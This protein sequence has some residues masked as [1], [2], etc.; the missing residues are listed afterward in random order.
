MTDYPFY[1][2]F[3]RF[4]HAYIGR[5]E[6]HFFF[7]PHASI[8]IILV[9]SPLDRQQHSAFSHAQRTR[10]HPRTQLFF[11]AFLFFF[12]YFN[13][14]A[15]FVTTVAS[16]P[17]D[18]SLQKN[19]VDRKESRREHFNVRISVSRQFHENERDLHRISSTEEMFFF[20][21][22]VLLEFLFDT[23]YVTINYYG[24]RDF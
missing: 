20:G 2:F 23:I 9:R 15:H 12:F 19:I 21:A 14:F 7:S 16:L 6:T 17:L 22:I 5:L 8:I 11:C 18:I 1:F 4:T 13:Y 3:F 10:R 24:T